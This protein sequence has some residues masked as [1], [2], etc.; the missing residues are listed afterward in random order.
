MFKTDYS[1]T[2]L[3]SDQNLA[4]LIKTKGAIASCAVFTKGFLLNIFICM[5]LSFHWKNL[6]LNGVYWLFNN[7]RV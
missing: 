7:T 5:D 2:S 6:G 3:C 4:G 1:G